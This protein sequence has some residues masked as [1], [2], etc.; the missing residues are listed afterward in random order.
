[1]FI[2]EFEEIRL[3]ESK[4][5]ALKIGFF[6][7]ARSLEPIIIA[8]T[9]LIS[10]INGIIFEKYLLINQF[11]FLLVFFGSRGLM[12][13]SLLDKINRLHIKYQEKLQKEWENRFFDELSNFKNENKP[14]ISIYLSHIY[15]DCVDGLIKWIPLKKQDNKKINVV[16]P[17]KKLLVKILSNSFIILSGFFIINIITNLFSLKNHEILANIFISIV[18]NNL[19]I[20]IIAISFVLNL[21]SIYL[22]GIVLFPKE[23]D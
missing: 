13:N 3:N 1:M 16:E 19:K 5:F 7:N 9:F 4:I 14:E 17:I 2:N 21:I 12:I 8:I 10:F 15:D 22:T 23:L 11:V 18:S 20:Y 6:I